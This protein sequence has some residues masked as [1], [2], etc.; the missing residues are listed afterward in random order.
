MAKF[1]FTQ[2]P[3]R[4]VMII[5]PTLFGDNR[6]YFM[7][8]YNKRDFEEAGFTWEFVQDN[9]SLSVKGVLR[10]I[11]FQYTH[12]QEKLVRVIKGEVFDVV[13]DL[14]KMSDTFGKW[15]G[16]ILS[17]TNKRMLYIPK[18]FGHGFLVLSDNAEFAYKCSDFYYPEDEGGIIWNDP[19][20]GIEWP[21]KSIEEVQL[22]KKDLQNRRLIEIS[23]TLN[24]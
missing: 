22:S 19:D 14:R 18:G 23:E 5:E 21:I 8:T 12:P 3:L 20:I 2:V 16:I 11:H 15:Y 1:I 10:G 17:E 7:E 13:V 9:Q 4:D 24:F 6:G